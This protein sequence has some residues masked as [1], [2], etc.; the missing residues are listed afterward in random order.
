[1]TNTQTLIIVLAIV[2]GFGVITA[3]VLPF[4]KKKGI[5]T[6]KYLDKANDA[7]STM[8]STLAILR[9]FIAQG[10]NMAAV[11]KLLSHVDKAVGN[12]EQLYKLDKLPAEEREAAARKYIADTAQ[13]FGV[14]MTPE[15]NA[16]I[17]GAIQASVN[18]LGHEPK[19]IDTYISGVVNGDDMGEKKVN[20]PATVP[21]EADNGEN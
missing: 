4:L 2:V 17:D 19:Y 16:L 8:N 3:I 14:E 1:M 12:A 20:D 21:S 10:D 13:V 7:L 9:P 11:D 18:A 15:V 6:G 5:D